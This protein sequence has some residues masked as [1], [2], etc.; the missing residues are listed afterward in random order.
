MKGCVFAPARLLVLLVTITPARISASQETGPPTSLDEWTAGLRNEDL[1]TRRSTAI[2]TRSANREIQRQLLDV[3]ADLLQKETD[4]Q[5]R[6]AV[7]DTVTDLGPEAELAVPALI[8]TLRSE[9]GGKEHEELHQDYRSALALAAIG[10]PAVEGLRSVL[11]EEAVNVRAEA[12]MALGRI[13]TGASAAVPDLIRLLADTS[14][15]VRREASLALGRM[16]EPAVEALLAAAAEGDSAIRVGAV[17]SLAQTAA[18]EKAAEAVLRAARDGDPAVR[19]AAV[20]SLKELELPDA[21]RTEILLENLRHPDEAVQRAA[22]NTLALDHDGLKQVAPKLT[23]LLAGED[24]SVSRLAAFLL[25]QQGPEAAPMLLDALQSDRSRVDQIATALALIGPRVRE[26]L[27]AAMTHPDP[28]V[29]S[30]AALALGQLRPL[31]ND[32]VQVVAAGLRDSSR[33][34][35]SACLTA[36]GQLGFRG[37]EAVPAVRRMLQDESAA[38]RRQA[39]TILFAAA[40][41]NEAL[42]DDLIDMTRDEDS[43]VQCAAIDAIRSTGPP[44]LRALTAV[45]ERLRSPDLSVRESAV[46]MIGSHGR[47]AAAAVPA[48]IELLEDDETKLRVAVS[49]TLSQLGPAA[50]PAFERLVLLVDDE[51]PSVRAAVVRTIA[52]ID[53]APMESRPW[54]AGALR[55]EEYTVRREGFRAIQRLGRRAAIF[56]PDLIALADDD[57]RSSYLN[58]VLEQFESYDLDVTT[59]AELLELLQHEH[60]GVRLLAIRFLGIAGRAA[61]DAIPQ[62]KLLLSDENEEIRT[63]AAEALQR[64]TE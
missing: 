63:A 13:G 48:L 37:R 52:N 21:V 29:R 61:T 40:E 15:R 41:R 32:T 8:H 62:L 3:L 55:D 35:Q 47:A 58:R 57:E 54:V 1:Q 44:G 5:V 11:A 38:V 46:A 59:A 20:A 22:A 51:E 43:G 16:G 19:A 50:R 33:D 18:N 28:R 60:S 36:I 56:L 42:I 17:S 2:A 39:V 12:A 6:L 45:I 10:Q 25:Q 7:F 34:V 14:P 24:E 4:G 9:Y 31:S 53:L 27:L 30:G 49:E 26:Q 23:D 64:I